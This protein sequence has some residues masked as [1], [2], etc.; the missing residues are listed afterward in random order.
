MRA[1]D[2]KQDGVA[3]YSHI[4]YIYTELYSYI[5]TEVFCLAIS[6]KKQ[7]NG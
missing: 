3:L 6:R 4:N 2:R 7:R 5:V 1:V